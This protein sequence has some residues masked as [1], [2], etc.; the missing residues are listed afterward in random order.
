[1]QLHGVISD[2]IHKVG[3]VEE[4]I[5]S[6]FIGL[7]NPEDKVHY[8]KIPSFTD[9]IKEVKIPYVLDYNIEVSI[10]KNQFG[11]NLE[12]L[13]LPGVLENFSKIIV[14]SR[15]SEKSKAID[16]WLEDGKE[17][18]SYTDPQFHLL[19]MELYTG[20]IP[21]W[22]KDQDIKS[23]DVKVKRALL[24]ESEEDGINGVTGRE[25]INMF[26]D[27]LS[28]YKKPNHLIMMSEVEDFFLKSKSAVLKK[29]VG[30][31]FIL[32]M[33]K[34][35]DY[36][37]LQEVKEC[38]YY[39]NKEQIS[40]DILNYLYALSFDE[41]D[42]LY[43]PYTD[44]KI[45]LDKNFFGV[46]ESVLFSDENMDPTSFRR[47]VQ[48]TYVSQTLAQEMRIEGREMQETTL[49]IKLLN[50]YKRSLKKNALMPFVENENFRRALL[51]F[52]RTSFEKYDLRLKESIKH[53]LKNLI[54]K[55]GYTQQGAIQVTIYLIDHKWHQE[56]HQPG[57]PPIN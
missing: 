8:A 48:T 5:K 17:Y 25:S 1:M 19:K 53:L 41:G 27:F 50:K 14:S 10:F 43:N 45:T 6:L 46:L 3:L 55:Y 38:I 42:Q 29:H 31:D 30:K 54:H 40:K 16:Q 4:R 20:Q 2:G 34:I 47:E 33:K 36:S 57:D 7:V 26:R 35:Y 32:S 9:R 12:A 44:E 37:L 52:N 39:Y 51:E 18:V 24:R 49:F 28:L 56:L 23:F 11:A 15:F 21:F 13:F 22:I